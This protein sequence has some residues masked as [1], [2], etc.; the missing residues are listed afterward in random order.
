M[1]IRQFNVPLEGVSAEMQDKLA[2]PFVK[3][4]KRKVLLIS[5]KQKAIE[6]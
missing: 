3:A 5:N 1:K 4:R 6:K 2:L